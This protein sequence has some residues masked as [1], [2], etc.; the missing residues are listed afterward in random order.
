MI[1]SN[2]LIVSKDSIAS[3]YEALN[4]KEA[5]CQYANYVGL[6]ITTNLFQKA[7]SSMNVEEAVEL[8]NETCLSHQDRIKQILTEYATLYKKE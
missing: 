4:V 6:T 7:I 1:P 2:Y 3:I 8:F 5:I